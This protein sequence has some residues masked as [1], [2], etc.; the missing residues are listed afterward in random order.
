[1]GVHLTVKIVSDKL[2]YPLLTKYVHWGVYMDINLVVKHL[3]SNCKSRRSCSGCDMSG[4]HSM[5]HTC[6]LKELRDTVKDKK[7][8]HFDEEF[9]HGDFPVNKSRIMIDG[10]PYGVAIQRLQE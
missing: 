5:K 8:A 6:L 4:K 2:F 3:E 7:Q 10:V 9:R 1:M